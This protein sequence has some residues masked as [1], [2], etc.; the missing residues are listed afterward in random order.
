MKSSVNNKYIPPSQQNQFVAQ[1]AFFS[2]SRNFLILYKNYTSLSYCLDDDDDDDDSVDD[3]HITIIIITILHLLLM[4]RNIPS[5]AAN[6]GS[7]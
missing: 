3:D 2:K 1:H 7:E 4:T 6:G 5:S